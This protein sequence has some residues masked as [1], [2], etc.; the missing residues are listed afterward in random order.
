[1]VQF[2]DPCYEETIGG[3]SATYEKLIGT[4]RVCMLP[5]GKG[6]FNVSTRQTLENFDSE[7][8]V[9]QKE[10]LDDGSVKI[11]YI[12]KQEYEESRKRER[13]EK[14]RL[15]T[16]KR[17]QSGTE[18]NRRMHIFQDAWIAEVSGYLELR[19]EEC[20][21][22]EKCE[23]SQVA[24]FV[25]T[26]TPVPEY[27]T[28]TSEN[29][30]DFSNFRIGCDTGSAIR[31]IPEQKI[32]LGIYQKITGQGYQRLKNSSSEHPVKVHIDKPSRP[33]E[34]GTEGVV[35]MTPFDSIQVLAQ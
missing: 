10:I 25:V 8:F 2:V 34:F 29:G 17:N 19:T 23:T 30:F 6:P 26:S 7:K 1:M 27:I 24:Y 18:E 9:E 11:V 21:S 15:E 31:Y 12:P 3:R 13:V 28:L 22:W 33:D 20:P 32:R 14:Q 4:E 35:C 5:A 16:E